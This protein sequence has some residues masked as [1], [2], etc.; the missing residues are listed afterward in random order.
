MH[1]DE[2]P[3]RDLRLGQKIPQHLIRFGRPRFSRWARLRNAFGVA[4]PPCQRAFQ[5]RLAPDRA[6]RLE[7]IGLFPNR[8]SPGQLDLSLFSAFQHP[9]PVQAVYCHLGP[10]CL[11]VESELGAPVY[12]LRSKVEDG[13]PDPLRIGSVNQI[14]RRG[15]G[16]VYGH[17]VS[18]HVQHDS[19]HASQFDAVG[20]VDNR[21]TVSSAH[22]A[23]FGTRGRSHQ[24]HHT[25]N[26]GSRYG[27]R[28]D[29]SSSVYPLF[30][31]SHAPSYV[32]RDNASTGIRLQDR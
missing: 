8:P 14:D 6:R 2:V 11:P 19:E 23:S 30:V 26:G 15:Q 5:I 29:E 32:L 22:F 9:G 27:R 7:L 17:L 4:L 25:G 31:H 10:G 16:R 21:N 1:V 12:T 3:P 13:L 28:L 24:G 20:C 18:R